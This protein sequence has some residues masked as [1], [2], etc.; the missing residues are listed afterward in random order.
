MSKFFETDLSQRDWSSRHV[1][2]KFQMV[3][4]ALFVWLV[5]N[6]E[7]SE[8]NLVFV[9]FKNIEAPEDILLFAYCFAIFSI[10]GFVVRSF[11]EA[12]PVGSMEPTH[13]ELLNEQIITVN[14]LRKLAKNYSSNPLKAYSDRSKLT[15][16]QR[17]QTRELFN[18]GG[19]SIDVVLTPEEANYVDMLKGQ[20][21]ALHECSK[22]LKDFEN[23]LRPYRS[24][25]R[26]LTKISQLSDE[27][28]NMILNENEVSQKR[29]LE[30]SKRPNVVL[31]QTLLS[32]RPYK[33]THWSREIFGA[34]EHALLAVFVPLGFALILLIM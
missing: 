17:L 13:Y 12:P 18:S 29:M 24:I 33:W 26:G 9:R 15:E 7:I 3:A 14:G 30:F 10:V 32:I 34:I 22:Q 25:M 1:R 23:D 11:F 5:K 16:G 31:E 27:F 8:V 19:N 4:S 21:L 20:R 28:L 6:F 2:L